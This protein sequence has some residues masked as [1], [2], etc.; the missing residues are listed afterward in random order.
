MIT[1]KGMNK[2]E[3]FQK[4]LQDPVVKDN[5]ELSQ[6]RLNTLELSTNSGDLLIETIKTLVITLEDS[7]TVS[8]RRV[9]QSLERGIR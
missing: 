7:E 6:E 5:T 9:I 4:Y 3:I 2:N 8:A 1:N